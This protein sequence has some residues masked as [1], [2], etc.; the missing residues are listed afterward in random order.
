MADDEVGVKDMVRMTTRYPPD[1]HARISARASHRGR[2]I[3]AEVVLL[4]EQGLAAAEGAA[5]ATDPLAAEAIAAL[6]AEK[7]IAALREQSEAEAIADRTA[8][9]VLGSL[10]LLVGR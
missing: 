1:L 6:V 8:E 7:V 2:S 4:L 10:R 3:Q 9:K 5:Q